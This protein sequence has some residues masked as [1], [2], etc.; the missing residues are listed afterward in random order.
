[1]KS[2]AP[3]DQSPDGSAV[4]LDGQ[5]ISTRAHL[6]KRAPATKSYQTKKTREWYCRACGHRVTEARVRNGEWGH[7]RDCTHHISGG[8]FGE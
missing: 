7:A 5:T 4:Q 2:N 8:G 6:T 3:T 1:M